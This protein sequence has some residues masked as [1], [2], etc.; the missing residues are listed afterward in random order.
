MRQQVNS[1]EPVVYGTLKVP[2]ILNA[3]RISN[4]ITIRKSIQL[5][6]QLE[7]INQLRIC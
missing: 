5:C 1:D 7:K 2:L 4:E 6:R 3:R